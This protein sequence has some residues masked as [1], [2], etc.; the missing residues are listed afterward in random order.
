MLINYAIYWMIMKYQLLKIM[1]ILA[2]NIN[3]LNVYSRGRFRIRQKSKMELFAQI[4]NGFK[5]LTIFA[6]SSILDVCRGS[7]SASVRTF[8]TKVLYLFENACP[9]C[10][11]AFLSSFTKSISLP[12]IRKMIIKIYS[13]SFIKV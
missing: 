10:L 2:T 3:I 12:K 6:K 5:S 9:L 11:L 4:V 7:K 1:T 8:F 13:K